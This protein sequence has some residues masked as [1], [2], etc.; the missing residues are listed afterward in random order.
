MPRSVPR[1]NFASLVCSGTT[2]AAGEKASHAHRVHV[3][4][5]R[6]H[7]V[8][9]EP[10]SSVRGP[11]GA[12]MSKSGSYGSSKPMKLSIAQA[13]QRMGELLRSMT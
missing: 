2:P 13:E 8:G 9:C 11:T 5:G 3:N 6:I 10:K 7:R 4:S 1:I 12:I